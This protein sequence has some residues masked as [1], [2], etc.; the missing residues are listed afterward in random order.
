MSTGRMQYQAWG[1]SY[2]TNRKRKGTTMAITPR[3]KWKQGHRQQYY[4]PVRNCLSPA[5]YAMPK[6]QAPHGLTNSFPLLTEEEAKRLDE[7]IN[8]KGINNEK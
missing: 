2:E 4:K 8:K 7:A 6:R 1:G 5:R 3:E